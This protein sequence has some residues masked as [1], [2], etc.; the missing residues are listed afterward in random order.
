MGRNRSCGTWFDVAVLQFERGPDFSDCVGL[1]TA[2]DTA[3]ERRAE[4]WI[5]S[6]RRV[7]RI[8]GQIRDH[9]EVPVTVTLEDDEAADAQVLDDRR[10]QEADAQPPTEAPLGHHAEKAMIEVISLVGSVRRSVHVASSVR[11]LTLPRTGLYHGNEY[12]GGNVTDVGQRMGN[13]G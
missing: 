10:I 4:G 2:Q 13:T 12:A 3:E 9:A 6:D 1:R 11:S 5:G 8:Q 7:G